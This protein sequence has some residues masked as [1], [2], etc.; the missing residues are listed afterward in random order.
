MEQE[1]SEKPGTQEGSA[2]SAMMDNNT[3]SLFE[4]ATGAANGGKV[5][6]TSYR[7]APQ[8]IGG[9][10]SGGTALKATTSSSS[11]G[12][13]SN[14]TN[15]S[16]EDSNDESSTMTNADRGDDSTMDEGTSGSP[17]ADEAALQVPVVENMNWIECTKCGKWRLLEKEVNLD[18]LPEDWECSMNPDKNANNCSAPEMDWQGQIEIRYGYTKEEKAKNKKGGPKKKSGPPPGQQQKKGAA[19]G[20]AS[21]GNTK[22]RTRIEPAASKEVGTKKPVKRGKGGNSG[23][24]S[25]NKRTTQSST[26]KASTADS[27]RLG[28]QPCPPATTG[29]PL[30]EISGFGFVQ[31]LP[32]KMD[33]QAYALGEGAS[34]LVYQTNE[35]NSKSL[36]PREL[37]QNM[38][39]ESHH[40]FA[41]T[42]LYNPQIGSAVTEHRMPE[43]QY[44][45][46]GNQMS[47]NENLLADTLG[48]YRFERDIAPQ[49]YAQGSSP[50]LRTTAQ[51]WFSDNDPSALTDSAVRARLVNGMGKI[52]NS[53]RKDYLD[54]SSICYEIFKGTPYQRVIERHPNMKG[55]LDAFGNWL[56][57]FRLKQI[58]GTNNLSS[59]EDFSGNALPGAAAG[60]HDSE[61]SLSWLADCWFSAADVVKEIE[62][63]LRT[64]DDAAFDGLSMNTFL[65]LRTLCHPQ[66]QTLC[67][68]ATEYRLGQLAGEGYLMRSRTKPR[69][70]RISMFPSIGNAAEAHGS[71]STALQSSS[72]HTDDG[73]CAEATAPSST[74]SQNTTYGIFSGTASAGAATTAHSQIVEHNEKEEENGVSTGSSSTVDTATTGPAASATSADNGQGKAETTPTDEQVSANTAISSKGNSPET[75]STAHVTSTSSETMAVSEDSTSTTAATTTQE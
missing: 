67:A 20:S 38:Q 6:L 52:Y 3:M 22:K 23:P 31:N 73:E 60:T 66:L 27:N 54:S 51:R 48:E 64:Q 26:T 59:K 35:F 72:S 63:W 71:T 45:R 17:P 33:T 47:I 49:Q 41:S 11:L 68:E 43:P 39:R 29:A 44:N 37:Q 14:A 55:C 18:D 10:Q 42:S 30:P 74:T 1:A 5:Q 57:S 24:A 15:A 62:I 25:T 2:E 19:P 50:A 58:I 36:P 34:N 13:S 28:K 65:A 4:A 56:T 69:L 46:R 8:V 61:K 40:R 16:M 12:S 32:P 9:G 75:T 70:F 7:A 21:K 53:V